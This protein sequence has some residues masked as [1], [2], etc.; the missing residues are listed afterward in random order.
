MPKVPLAFT[1]MVFVD[2]LDDAPVMLKL[3]AVVTEPLLVKL[4]LLRVVVAAWAMLPVV[5]TVNEVGEP[6]TVLLTVI[7]LLMVAVDDAGGITGPV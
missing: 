4:V 6:A 3:P 7:A 1:V 2:A 5:L